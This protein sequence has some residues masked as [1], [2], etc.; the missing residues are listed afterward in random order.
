MQKTFLLLSLLIMPVCCLADLEKGKAI[1]QERCSSCHGA[2]GTGDGAI[3]AGLPPEM[4]PRNLAE[5][6]L[7]VATDDAKLKELILKG[8]TPFGLNPL[9]APQAGL[10]DQDLNS[11]ISFVRSLHKK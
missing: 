11:L 3:A 1:F 7:K 6:V 5:G 9:M 8:G 4:K 10:S 2:Q